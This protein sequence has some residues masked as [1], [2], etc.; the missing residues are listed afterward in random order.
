M[1]VPLKTLKIM[2]F[3]IP[4]VCFSLEID[5]RS[6][7]WFLDAKSLTDIVSLFFLKNDGWGTRKSF[8]T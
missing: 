1:V 6:F 4:G 7:F 5:Y 2:V 8:E 3:R